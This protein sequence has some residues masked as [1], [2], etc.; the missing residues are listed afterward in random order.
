MQRIVFHVDMDAF[1]AS[2]E[3]RDNP[4]YRG[5]PVI[6]GAR[7]GNRGVV[8]TASYEARKYGIHSAMPINE[9]YSRCP[10]GVFLTPNMHLYKKVSDEIAAIL[11]QFSPSMERVSVDEAF[12]DMTGTEKLFGTHKEAAKLISAEIQASQGITCSIGIASNK[13]VAKI[14]SDLNKPNG[15]T[16]A[17]FDQDQVAQWLAPLPVNRMWGVGKKSSDILNRISVVTIGDL[18][19]LSFEYLYQRFGKQGAAFYYLSRGC[20]SRPVQEEDS[21]KSI[22]R[23]HTYNVDSCNRQEWKKTLH[24]LSQDVARRARRYGVKGS[25]VYLTYRTPDFQ[26]HSRRKPLMAPTNVAKTIYDTVLELLE[27]V[28]ERYIRLIGVGITGFNEQLQTDLFSAE[29]TPSTLEASERAVDQIIARF[30]SD[31]IK[32]GLEVSNKTARK[33]SVGKSSE[34]NYN[35][36]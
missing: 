7:P 21:I 15:I 6:I 5:K 18:Q 2:I 23:E 31:V 12:L 34:I 27:L 26:R 4:Q 11:D 20:D 8:S 30:G 22:S 9:A 1:Y 29:D 14:A 35:V 24:T 32:K 25:T 33:K 3:Q 16:C 36:R 13:F 10:H 17:P 19:K 28:N